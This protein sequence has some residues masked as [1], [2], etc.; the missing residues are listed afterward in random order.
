MEYH[1]ILLYPCSFKDHYDMNITYA[2]YKKYINVKILSS[3]LIKML[4]IALQ[5]ND[6]PFCKKLLEFDKNDKCRYGL[7]EILKVC[8]ILDSNRYSKKRKKKINFNEDY[9]FSLTSSKIK[10]IINNWIKKIPAN[11]LEYYALY[12]PTNK[13]KKLIKLLHPKK[14]D[15]ALN[16]FMSYI[17]E[18]YDKCP[19]DA[20]FKICSNLNNLNLENIIIKYHLD[21]RYL[22]KNKN[23][24]INKYIKTIIASYT[25]LNTLLYYWDEFL[26][27]NDIIIDKY[28]NSNK[29]IDLSYG[30]IINKLLYFKNSTGISNILLKL[31]T[32]K[33]EKYKKIIKLDCP[34]VVLGDG[35]ASMNIAIETSSIITSIL[36]EICFAEYRIFRNTDTKIDN[37]LL[38]IDKIIDFSNN[39]KAY[40]TTCPVASLFPYYNEKKIVKTFIIVTDEYENVT[41]RINNNS[42]IEY[43]NVYNL[44]DHNY[45]TNE[46]DFARLFLLY[47]QEIYNLTKIIFISFGNNPNNSIMINRIKEIIP[48]IGNDLICFRMDIKNPNLTKLDNILETLALYNKKPICNKLSPI[49]I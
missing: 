20:L 47:R 40:N 19:D 21:Y 14:T 3:N 44:K 41:I 22:R 48:N 45:D 5:N 34:I 43:N 25:P 42:I 36:S 7:S 8:E 1:N 11:I 28:M 27:I 29:I 9:K 6:K 4:V 17:F 12:Y 16:W 15:F 30:K 46:Y 39:C 49:V 26:D 10:F 33:F 32:E 35:S 38:N 37:K 18:D 24:N 13:W 31:A 2:I 23:I